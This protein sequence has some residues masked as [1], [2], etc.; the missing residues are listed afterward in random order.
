[1]DY[2][3]WDEEDEFEDENREVENKSAIIIDVW[4]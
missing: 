1:M 2:C 4:Y 3:R